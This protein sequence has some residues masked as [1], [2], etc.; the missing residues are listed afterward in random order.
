MHLRGGLATLAV[1]I[2]AN[3][4]ADPVDRD[5]VATVLDHFAARS[6]AHFY[7]VEA[8]LAI[9][10]K[11]QQMKDGEV[12]Y[13]YVNEDEGHC[14]IPKPLYL[15]LV[16]R[17]VKSTAAAD[18][19]SKSTK[20]FVVRPGEEDKINPAF[21]PPPGVEKRK[22]VKTLVSLTKPAYSS[23]GLTALVFLGFVWSI[24]SA[25]AR[26]VLRRESDRWV[27]ACSQ[28]LFSV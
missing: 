1:V 11:T 15:A 3:A 13:Q 24:H 19:L 9:Q 18:L 17:N 14:S 28:L 27:V 2:A 5:V 23:D 20:W 12:W 21:L 6:D 25:N 22:P 10:P 16:S 8:K 4:W 26:Y 7:D